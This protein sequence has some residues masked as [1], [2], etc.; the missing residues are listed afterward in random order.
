MNILNT[1]GNTPLIKIDNIYAKLESVNP[2]GSIKDRIALEII[3]LAEKEGILKPGM[4]IIEGTS[5]N[6]GISLAMVAA[7]KNYKMVVVMPEHMSE[8]RKQMIKAFGAELILTSK[9]GSFTEAVEKAEKLSKKS[10]YWMAGQ[11]TNLA[12]VKAQE[13][14]AKEVFDKIGEV[15]AV[16]AGV[17]TGG[18]LMGFSNIMRMVNPNVKIFA[19]EPEEAS[20]MFKKADVTIKEHQIQG[21]GDG[22]IPPLIDMNRVDDVIRVSSQKAMEMSRKLTKEQGLLV[23]ISSGANIVAAQK[24]SSQFNKIATVLPDRGERYLSMGLYK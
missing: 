20:V 23:G 1:I 8:E 4:T 12:N 22:F 7:V 19:V 9:K 6:T 18:T 14:T 17:G 5:G 24:I 3:E 11:F 10:G 16:V 13:K 21:I 2:T 15:D